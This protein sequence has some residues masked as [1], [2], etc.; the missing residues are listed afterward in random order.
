MKT[1]KIKVGILGIGNCASALI[2]GV[3]YCKHHKEK[4]TGIL[5]RDIAGYNPEDI[6][7]VAA[8]D[9]DQRKVGADLSTAIWQKPNCTKQFYADIPA[10]Q[11]KVN[12][13]KVF[14]G[15]ANHMSTYETDRTFVLSEEKEPSKEEI[16]QLLKEAEVDVLVNFL[17]VGSD[18]AT[19]FYAQC[20]IDAGIALVNSIPVFL[21]SDPEWAESFRKAGVPIVGDDLKAQIGAT[22]THR[23]LT[24]LFEQ[25]GVELKHTYQLNIGGNTDFLNMLDHTRL[26]QKRESK[27]EAV[28]SV[29]SSRLSDTDIRI[30]PSDYVPWLDDNKVAY[31]R[32]EGNMIGG[33]PMNIEVRL[34]VED[35]PNAAAVVID[36]IRCA[37]LASE[38]NIGGPIIGPSS[39]LCKHPPEQ[40]PDEDALLKMRAFFES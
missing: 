5:H 9:I 24:R 17:P 3:Y 33:V 2:Q 26:N 23:A 4:A 22:I 8:F 18:K 27:T 7:F 36:A 1:K 11:V 30:G 37:K 21:A 14:D 35:S 34:S 6:D 16:I 13:G 12:M 39:F 29:T 32:M 31:M 25:R 28:Q 38:R 10:S 40:Y 19:K 15:L 20:A